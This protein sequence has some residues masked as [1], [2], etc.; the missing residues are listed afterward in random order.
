MSN[1]AEKVS[2]SKAIQL[3]DVFRDLDSEMPIGQA[4]S[5]LLI[6]QGETEEGGG[7][8]VTDLSRQGQFALSSS[9]RYVQC[10]GGRK[11]RHGRPGQEL[12]SDPRDPADDR[13]KVLRLT[14]KGNRIISRIHHT[15]G[16]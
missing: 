14:P 6:A 5:L 13:R 16:G 2:I 7:L 3:L 11:D 1:K 12:V 9:S 8:T 4:F 10:L 15:L